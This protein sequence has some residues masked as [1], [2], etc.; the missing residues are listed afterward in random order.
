MQSMRVLVADDNEMYGAM[1]SRFVASHPGIEVVGR[2]S[3]GGEAIAMASL[4]EPDMVLMDVCM[5]G[6]D[7]IDATRA[8][9]AMRRPAKVILLTAH[10]APDAE[11]LCMNAGASGFLRKADADAQLM[12]LIRSL[13]ALVPEAECPSGPGKDPEPPPN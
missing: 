13:S 11:Q 12:D 6:I 4:L 9:T 7:G 3:N 1:L 10:R 8:V 5:P 2:A